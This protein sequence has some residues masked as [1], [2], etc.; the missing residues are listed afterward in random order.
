MLPIT[1]KKCSQNGSNIFYCAK[2]ELD[3]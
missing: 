3:K 1:E 2:L